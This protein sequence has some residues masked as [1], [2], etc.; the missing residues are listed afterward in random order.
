[1]LTLNLVR[2]MLSLLLGHGIPFN[3]CA[4]TPL[5]ALGALLNPTTVL[6]NPNPQ[7]PLGS[8][9]QVVQVCA[10]HKKPAKLLKHLAAVKAASEGLRNPPR[11]LVFANRIKVSHPTVM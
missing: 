8:V 3:H 2:S 4:S 6:L 9:L 1:M 10:E 7:T 5:G 11:M